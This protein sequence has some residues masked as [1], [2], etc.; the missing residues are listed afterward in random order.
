MNK[1]SN[2][3][4]IVKTIKPWKLELCI[5]YSNFDH[6]QWKYKDRCQHFFLIEK[7]FGK[8]VILGLNWTECKSTDTV[9]N[10]HCVITYKIYKSKMVCR[11]W[12]KSET[13]YMMPSYL[14]DN[15]NSFLMYFYMCNHKYIR[16]L[17]QDLNFF[18]CCKHFIVIILSLNV[19]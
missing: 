18:K 15:I 16:V 1:T 9:S 17:K 11:S 4:P 5:S 13:L 14:K 10:S 2:V 6:V 8:Y 3:Y 12:N 7:M 19:L